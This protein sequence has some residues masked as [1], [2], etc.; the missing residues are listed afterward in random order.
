MED[1]ID[2]ADLNTVHSLGIPSA[3]GLGR[4]SGAPRLT[5]PKTATPPVEGIID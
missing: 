3:G 4:R 5:P 2:V 1:S